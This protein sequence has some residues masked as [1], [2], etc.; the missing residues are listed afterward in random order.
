VHAPVVPQHGGK[1]LAWADPAPA[2]TPAPTRLP[3]CQ[4]NTQDPLSAL[5]AFS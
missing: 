5:F 4:V 1:W 2:K 3:R